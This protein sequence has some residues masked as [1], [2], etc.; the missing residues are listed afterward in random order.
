MIL[1]MK[2]DVLIVGAGPSGLFCAYEL[3]QITNMRI[4][5]LEVGR[6]YVHY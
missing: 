2:Y 1:Y 5:I 4:A 3:S 6:P